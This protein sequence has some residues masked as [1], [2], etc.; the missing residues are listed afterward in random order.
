M[1]VR[2]VGVPARLRT[3]SKVQVSTMSRICSP[4]LPQAVV[5]PGALTVQPVM[6]PN[7]ISVVD[8]DCAAEA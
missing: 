4:L 2:A 6:V 7:T 8:T 5:V 1:K 3:A